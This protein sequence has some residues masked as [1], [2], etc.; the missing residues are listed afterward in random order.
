M[1]A[2]DFDKD[3]FPQTREYSLKTAL[4]QFGNRTKR[5]THEDVP[6]FKG[7]TSTTEYKAA[8][9]LVQTIVSGTTTFVA[10]LGPRLEK[11]ARKK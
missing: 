7:I 8:E 9:R 6:L 3:Y 1:S 10:D 2:E 4:E 11:L 5:N